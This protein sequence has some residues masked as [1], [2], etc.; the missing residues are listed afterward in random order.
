MDADYVELKNC[1]ICSGDELVPICSLGMQTVTGFPERPDEKMHKA[2]LEIVLCKKCNLLQMRYTFERELLYRHYWYESGISPM[3]V[4]ALSDIIESAQRIV[5]LNPGDYVTDIGSNDGTLLTLYKQDGIRKIG[6]EPSDVGYK[7]A[8]GSTIVHDFFNKESYWKAADTK[9]KIITSI[10]MFYDLP[11]PN[12]FVQDIKKCLSEDGVWVIQMNYLMLMLKNNT[13]DDICHEH[14]EYYSLNA[15]ENLLGRNG[16]KLIDA[17]LNSVNGGSIRVFVVDEK[18]ALGSGSGA[19]NLRKIREMEKA[20]ELSKI[21]TYEKFQRRMDENRKKVIE[22]MD[23]E[24]AKGKK[25]VIWGAS[26][27]GLVQVQYL[28]ITSK[29]IPYAIDKNPRKWGRYYSGTGIKLV[30]LEEAKKMK[31]DYV[32]VLPYHFLEEIIKESRPLTQNGAKLIV[33]IPEF[34]IIG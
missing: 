19:E 12:E 7:S 10:S 4:R 5:H 33:N 30:S 14:L 21:E 16:M 9:A 31:P 25:F 20:M 2:P 29:Q 8:P 15:I 34:R 1:R 17:E 22:F 11:N 3:M 18:S 6:F 27:R 32:L 23:A 13:Y 26:T 24:M 28:G